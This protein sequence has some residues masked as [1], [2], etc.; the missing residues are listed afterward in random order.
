MVLGGKLF[1]DS[2]PSDLDNET[3]FLPD[4]GCGEER[5][6]PLAARRRTSQWRNLRGLSVG[7]C[8]RPGAAFPYF[9]R[10]EEFLAAVCLSNTLIVLASP[11][12]FE[13]VL[14]P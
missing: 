2:L 7:V 5:L 6:P 1:G 13:P 14:P 4:R 9:F 12:G 8:A 11:T 10:M 3:A